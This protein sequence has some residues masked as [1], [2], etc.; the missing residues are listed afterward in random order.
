MRR[1]ISSLPDR[2]GMGV[3]E[4]PYFIVQCRWCGL[5]AFM[6]T[7]SP[8]PSSHYHSGMTFQ[9][10]W[11]NNQHVCLT[12]EHYPRNEGSWSVHSK[13][14]H[15]TVPPKTRRVPNSLMSKRWEL[16][17]TR[18]A[19]WRAHPSPLACSSS[20]A[21]NSHGHEGPLFHYHQD[22]WLI[23]QFSFSYLT[24]EKGLLGKSTLGE[25][26]PINDML[27]LY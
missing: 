11:Q 3:I 20:S 22:Q 16:H 1:R 17:M 25:R 2:L 21:R 10:S 12:V 24:R 7:N 4:L 9:T 18:Y 27:L 6:T 5:S 15:K 8:L 14:Q 26:P 19:N 23:P 13:D